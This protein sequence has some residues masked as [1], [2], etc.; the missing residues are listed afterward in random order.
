MNKNF[1]FVTA[2]V[3]ALIGTGLVGYISFNQQPASV[4]NQ[5]SEKKEEEKTNATSTEPLSEE[6]VEGAENNDPETQQETQNLTAEQEII[7]SILLER[8]EIARSGDYE[9]IRESFAYGAP[10]EKAEQSVLAQSDD[11]TQ[12]AV[13]FYLAV[14]PEPLKYEMLIASTTKWEIG[15]TQARVRFD[16]GPRTGVLD[17]YN[18]EGQWR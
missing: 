8:D 6:N 13:E 11:R 4:V 14:V 17:V 16:N 5:D 1:Y 12:N 7:A 18:R 15:E 10:S 3:I 9:K 2:L